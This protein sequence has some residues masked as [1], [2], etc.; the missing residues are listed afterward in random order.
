MGS[1]ICCSSLE[2]K[3]EEKETW[4]MSL[5]IQIMK[6]DKRLLLLLFNNQFY[7]EFYLNK[8]YPQTKTTLVHF[9]KYYGQDWFF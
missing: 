4:K 7:Q 5:S 9:N 1:M 6:T 3:Y 8:H 2:G